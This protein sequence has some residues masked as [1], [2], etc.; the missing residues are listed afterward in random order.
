MSATSTAPQ[1]PPIFQYWHTEDVPTY[2]D[3]LFESFR[4]HNLDLCQRIFSESEAEGFIAEHFGLREV[5]AFRTCAVPS[6]QSD[7]FRYCS[8]LACGGIYADADYR[9]IR[10]LRPLLDRSEGGEIFLGPTVHRFEGRPTRHIW[11]GFFAFREPGHPFLRLAL[12]IATANLEARIPERVWPVGEK[13]VESIWLTVGPGVPTLMRFI[14]DCGSFDAFIERVRGSDADPFAN[15]YCETIGDYGRIVEAFEG[16]YVSPYESMC[17]WV[18][19]SESVL[20]Y[21][22]TDVHW[23]NVNGEIFRS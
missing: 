14:R 6:M 19:N 10:P 9:C 21:K 16:M 12:D 8:V 3:D 1:A 4:H 2:I 5:E 17:H 20:P 13:V 7:Y 23:Q 18:G 15:L 22:E 11:S